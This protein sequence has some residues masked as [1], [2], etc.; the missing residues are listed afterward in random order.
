MQ[1]RETEYRETLEGD[2]REFMEHVG[3]KD[4]GCKSE[5]GFVAEYEDG[6][7]CGTGVGRRVG[8]YYELWKG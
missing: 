5:V 7:G 8:E 6:G 3:L 2:G 1:N 4:L